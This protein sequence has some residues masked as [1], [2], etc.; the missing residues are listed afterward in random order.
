MQW[1]FTYALGI[2]CDRFQIL[3]EIIVDTNWLEKIVKKKKKLKKCS[4]SQS[5]YLAL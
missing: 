1:G 3:Y 5:V 4:L 2:F